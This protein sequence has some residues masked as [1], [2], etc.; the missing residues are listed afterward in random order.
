MAEGWTA[1]VV[2]SGSNSTLC[3]EKNM[4]SFSFISMWKMF[5][6][7]QNFQGM[8]RKKLAFISIKVKYSLLPVTSC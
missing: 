7:T 2:S 1:V 6:L 3:S 8:L 4:L 5:R